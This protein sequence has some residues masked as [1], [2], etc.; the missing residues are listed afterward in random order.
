MYSSNT[1]LCLLF[2][3][4]SEPELL[5]RERG[6]ASRV[7]PLLQVEADHSAPAERG[8]VRPAISLAVSPSD[9]FFKTQPSFKKTAH[10]MLNDTHTA[11]KL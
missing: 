3:L 5:L 7:S 2:P 8:P 6:L 1:H 10:A 11:A 9:S 4:P